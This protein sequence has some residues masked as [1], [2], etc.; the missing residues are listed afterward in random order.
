M[1]QQYMGNISIHL[2]TPVK[3]A[4]TLSALYE[5]NIQLTQRATEQTIASFVKLIHTY[6]YVCASCSLL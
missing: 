3:A 4:D 1:A 2:G 6:G 5:D